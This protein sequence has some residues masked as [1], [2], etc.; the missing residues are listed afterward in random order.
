M[1]D[2]DRQYTAT[3]AVTKNTPSQTVRVS[4]DVKRKTDKT[5]RSYPEYLVARA[6]R[7][8]KEQPNLQ[9]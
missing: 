2:L 4:N 5:K 7:H 1:T 3:I 6:I 8:K 9:P